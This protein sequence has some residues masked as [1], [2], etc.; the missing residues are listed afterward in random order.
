MLLIDELW[1]APGFAISS[2]VDKMNYSRPNDPLYQ[3]YVFGHRVLSSIHP[4]PVTEE[5]LINPMAPS[6]DFKYK[7]VSFAIMYD[8]S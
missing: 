7:M 2:T 4:M 8:V 5:I 6:Q 1:R 3:F